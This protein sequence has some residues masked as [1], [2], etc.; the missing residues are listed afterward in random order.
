MILVSD[1][2]VY[3]NE[4]EEVVSGHSKVLEVATIGIKDVKSGEVPIS[5]PNGSVSEKPKSSATITNTFGFLTSVAFAKVTHSIVG[6]NNDAIA[7]FFITIT[8]SL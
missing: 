5:L 1:F 3:P 6:T 7:S 8:I 2:N 4:I